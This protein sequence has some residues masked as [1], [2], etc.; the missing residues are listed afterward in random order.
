MQL[1]EYPFVEVNSIGKSLGS[2]KIPLI[3]ISNPK[4]Q[5]T[6]D[7]LFKSKAVNS[8]PFT[9]LDLLLSLPKIPQILPKETTKPVVIIVGR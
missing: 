9:E 1:L 8:L 3:K 4:L 5:T 6:F 2:I 7:D